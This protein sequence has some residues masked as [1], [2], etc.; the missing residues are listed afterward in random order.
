MVL[1]SLCLCN[2]CILPE[3]I[4]EVFGSRL[5]RLGFGHTPEDHE[6]LEVGLT[7]LTLRA[8]PNERNP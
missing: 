5:G 6:M 1:F 4:P 3:V 7:Q 8:P 2:S